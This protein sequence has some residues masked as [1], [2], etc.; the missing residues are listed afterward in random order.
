MIRQ[1][2]R[3]AF[4]LHGSSTSPSKIST[5]KKQPNKRPCLVWNINGKTIVVLILTTFNNEHSGD[6][7]VLYILLTRPI[8]FWCFYAG[9]GPLLID[10]G[11]IVNI[12]FP[13]N[14]L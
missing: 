14:G 6:D 2:V 11:R 9:T 3:K 1:N 12:N 13:S 10:I 8:D 5:K 4:G 7:A